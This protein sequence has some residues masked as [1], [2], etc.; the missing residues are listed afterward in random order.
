MLTTHYLPYTK[1]RL[2]LVNVQIYD[3]LRYD[4]KK[5]QKFAIKKIHYYLSS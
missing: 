3:L 1:L 5:I 4:L 2:N